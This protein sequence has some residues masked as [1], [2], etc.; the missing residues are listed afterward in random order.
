MIDRPSIR[1]LRDTALAG[2]Q[3]S[4][5]GLLEALAADHSEDPMFKEAL[6]LFMVRSGDRDGGHALL[7]E[8]V[9]APGHEADARSLTIL[10]R[11]AFSVQAYE[12]AQSLADRI[13]AL[14]PRSQPALRTA[15]RIA[16]QNGEPDRAEH[17]WRKL[18][19]TADDKRE[20]ALQISRL[21]R[22]REDWQTEAEFADLAL[23]YEPDDPEAVALAVQ[24]RIRS[25]NL[26]GLSRLMPVLYRHD[27]ERVYGYLRALGGP[28]QALGLAG[29]LV[30]FADAGIEDPVI[31]QLTL[32]SPK[33]WLAIGRRAARARKHELAMRMFQ[34]TLLLDTTSR[35]AIEGL[36]GLA[37]GDLG[38]MRSALKT[39][40]DVAALEHAE[41]VVQVN[42]ASDE[43]WAVLGRLLLT[44]NPDRAVECLRTC[45][46]LEP[47]DPWG[48]LNLA[49]ALDETDRL[50]EASETYARLAAL[51]ST[52]AK[53]HRA[54]AEKAAA[55]VRRKALRQAR[56]AFA[57]RRLDQAW[58]LCLLATQGEEPL[59]AGLALMEVLKRAKL[60]QIRE[61]YGQRS[62]DLID[63]AEWYLHRDPGQREI[64]VYLGRSLMAE[65]RYERALTVWMELAALE[66]S[67]SY[68]QAQI[69]RCCKILKLPEQGAIAAANAIRLDPNSDV[70]EGL[71]KAY[72]L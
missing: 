12:K 64:M 58:E 33:Q 42:P 27:P 70:S 62:A 40:D 17:Y 19:E 38:A 66:P 69:A 34:A 51:E 6:G 23:K 3:T 45:V 22:G 56:E 71:R 7:E 18:C 37:R 46:E 25:R 30:G 32:D 55:A 9:D 11:N 47:D 21:A 50:G 41:R 4:V 65:R 57:D 53:A 44:T 13:L 2:D 28:E 63:T 10:M 59:A 68:F 39:A 36:N 60:L 20:P 1:E 49:R 16:M 52:D 67:D 15:A 61:L 14:E 48:L 31:A 43:A 35:D 8:I 29:V 24:A 72:N 26:D 54:E 5:A